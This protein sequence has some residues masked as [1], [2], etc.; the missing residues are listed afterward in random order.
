MMIHGV[1]LIFLSFG[2]LLFLAGA[3]GAP[4]G[5]QQSESPFFMLGKVVM[6]QSYVCALIAMMVTIQNQP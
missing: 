3:Q 4:S 1:N 6:Q 5:S 2:L